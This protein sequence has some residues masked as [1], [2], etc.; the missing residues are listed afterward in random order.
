M[1][2]ACTCIVDNVRS[3]HNTVHLPDDPVSEGLDA[4]GGLEGTSLLLRAEMGGT[5]QALCK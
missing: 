5:S 4:G 2:N 1:I 3:S